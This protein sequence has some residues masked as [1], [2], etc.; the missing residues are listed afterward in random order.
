MHSAECW[1]CTWNHSYFC[2]S[3][4]PRQCCEIEAKYLRMS[5]VLS[6]S[7]LS[8]TAELKCYQ[9]RNELLH[10]WVSMYC[11]CQIM[12]EIRGH[13]PIDTTAHLAL[14]KRVSLISFR[15]VSNEKQREERLLVNIKL[16]TVDWGHFALGERQKRISLAQSLHWLNSSNDTR[17]YISN[18]SPLVPQFVPQF[19]AQFPA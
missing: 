19:R 13:S 1:N 9:L 18:R 3:S 4:F 6:F 14:C 8:P 7:Y 11:T 12:E 17:K 5:I 2:P 16:L 10:G 15:I